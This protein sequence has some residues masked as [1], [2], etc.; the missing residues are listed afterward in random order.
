LFSF[1][2]IEETNYFKGSIKNV[3]ATKYIYKL[4]IIIEN[5]TKD[6]LVFDSRESRFEFSVGEQKLNGNEYII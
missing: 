4:A 2:E 6:Y 1:A 3:I 5:K